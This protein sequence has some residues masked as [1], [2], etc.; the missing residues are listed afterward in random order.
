MGGTAHETEVS[1]VLKKVLHDFEFRT[2]PVYRNMPLTKV[3][4][5]GFEINGVVSA[6]IQYRIN[7]IP[8]V[9]LELLCGNIEGK[10]EQIN[11]EILANKLSER[12]CDDDG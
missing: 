10:L 4:I 6:D 8:T 9:I 3:F 5:D 1:A 2:E 12:R 11:Y 7:E